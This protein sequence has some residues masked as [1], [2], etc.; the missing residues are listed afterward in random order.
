[1]MNPH[2]L[3]NLSGLFVSLGVF[4]VVLMLARH[5][6]PA[7][8]VPAARWLMA[9]W[10]IVGLLSLAAIVFRAVPLVTSG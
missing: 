8:D 4:I 5:R 7:A 1:M 10:I 2:L 6:R 9:G 3:G